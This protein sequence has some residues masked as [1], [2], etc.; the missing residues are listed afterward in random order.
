MK[1]RV[2]DRMRENEREREGGV[3]NLVA[4]LF[5]LSLPPSLTPSL[6]LPPLFLTI[7]LLLFIRI[8]SSQH[9][10]YYICYFFVDDKHETNMY[11]IIV[12]RNSPL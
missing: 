5:L 2:R 8:T 12:G 6:S 10:L 4:I 1:E 3:G 7:A 11:I 9:S